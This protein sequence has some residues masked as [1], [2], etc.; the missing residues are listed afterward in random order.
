MRMSVTFFLVTWRSASPLPSHYLIE[1]FTCNIVTLTKLLSTTINCQLFFYYYLV[2]YT[3]TWCVLNPQPHPP[4]NYY[5]RRKCQLS[6]GDNELL[7][8][9]LLC[10]KKMKKEGGIIGKNLPMNHIA[11]AGNK[12]AVKIRVVSLQLLI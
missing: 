2:R 8:W 5:G 3:P 1:D 4:T 12:I 10:W 7:T 11:A 6:I 9:I